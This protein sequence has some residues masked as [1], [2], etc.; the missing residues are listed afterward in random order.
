VKTVAIVQA[1]MGSIR[2]PEKVMQPVAGVPMIE[3][4]LT[5]LARSRQIDRIVLA[6]S[7]DR[8]NQPLASHVKK[9]GFDVYQGSENDVLD[10]YYQSAKCYEA[11]I[12]VRITGDCPLIDPQ[13]VD[14]IIAAFKANKVD[15]A[16]NTSPA[17]Y[18][19]G[20]DT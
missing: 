18:P 19:D 3:L 9:L 16:S 17:T 6:T 2:F 13:L 14:L 12:I 1:R 20:L 4:L 8:R 15:Y 5:R 11:E 7:D 10:R